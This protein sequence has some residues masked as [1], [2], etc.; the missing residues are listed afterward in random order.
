VPFVTISPSK[1]GAWRMA[2]AREPVTIEPGIDV[3]QY[4]QWEGDAPHILTVVNN[5]RRPLFDVENWLAL[6]EGLPEGS[7]RLVGEGNEGIPGAVGPAPSWE[8]LKAEYQHARLYLHPTAPPFEDADNLA[9]IEARACGMPVFSLYGWAR[10]PSERTLDVT[11]QMLREAI[12]GMRSF[13]PSVRKAVAARWS[14]ERFGAAWRE[15][16]EGAV[17]D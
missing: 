1:A 4:P 13:A 14:L 5:L 2:G 6:T 11:R 8:A 9:S 17:N 3:T 16:L 10:H 7:V 15:V 12:A